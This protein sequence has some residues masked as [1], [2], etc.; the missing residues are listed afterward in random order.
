MCV[1]TAQSGLLL[2]HPKC[3]PQVNKTMPKWRKRFLSLIFG[4]KRF[5]QYLYGRTCKFQILTDHKPVTSILGPKSGIPPLA[6]ARLKRWALLLT[7]YNYNIQYRSSKAHGNVDGLSC[8]PFHNCSTPESTEFN[9]YQRAALEVTARQIA[10]DPVLS[11]VVLYVRKGWP[12]GHTLPQNFQPYHNRFSELTV[13]QGCLLWG[14][15]VVV[16]SKFTKQLLKELHE[17]HSGIV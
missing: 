10:R 14:I 3:Y 1:L 17:S 2:M 7:G 5:H 8:L 4:L 6:A 9:V 15:R 16:P 11:K 12:M 13:E